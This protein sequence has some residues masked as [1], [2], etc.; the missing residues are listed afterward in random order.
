[1]AAWRSWEMAKGE[2]AIKKVNDGQL[3]SATEKLRLI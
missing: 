2:E 3:E 1:M